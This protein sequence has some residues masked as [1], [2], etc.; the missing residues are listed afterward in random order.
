[1]S[2]SLQRLPLEAL[3]WEAA[4]GLDGQG[5]PTYA[6]PVALQGRVVRTDSSSANSVVRMG[7]GEENQTVATIWLDAT[8]VGFPALDDRLTLADGFKGIVTERKEGKKLNGVL[9]HMQYKIRE[10]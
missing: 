8:A 4:S 5:K 3:V 10:E 2:I 1:M 9:D 6:A 7:G